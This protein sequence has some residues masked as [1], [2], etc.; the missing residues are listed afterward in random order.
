MDS[1]LFHCLTFRKEMYF[2][3]FTEVYLFYD[4]LTLN[5]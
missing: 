3:L 5:I 1:N 4:Q 2:D